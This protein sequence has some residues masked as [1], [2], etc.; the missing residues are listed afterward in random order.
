MLKSMWLLLD[1]LVRGHLVPLDQT[2][3]RDPAQDRHA[4]QRGDAPQEGAPAPETDRNQAQDRDQAGQDHQGLQDR[5]LGVE[6]GIPGAEGHTP[7]G[8]EEVEHG[9]PVPGGLQEEQQGRQDQEVTPGP[10]G[11]RDGPGRDLNAP[12]AEVHSDGGETR[13]NQDPH[14][15][16]IEGGPER[17][18]EHVEGHLL[19]EERVPDAERRR[20]QGL[21]DQLPSVCP[22]PAG[23][24]GQ[25][26][27]HGEGQ[28][29]EVWLQDL[30]TWQSGGVL[31]RHEGLARGEPP[32]KGHVAVQ[33]QEERGARDHP[34]EDLRP[35]H[36]DEDRRELHLAEPQP[37]G[38][39]AQDLADRAHKD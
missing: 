18:L 36:G 39:E 33:D 34:E 31:R 23:E 32:G 20:I 30:W 19:V 6:V 3:V 10:S 5:Q 25:R 14:Q 8:E 16:A 37:V 12:G 11:D 26:H 28:T 13:D 4:H 38:V 9:Q 27:A 15:P 24:E 2:R 21:Q 22:Q 17:E 35:E 1:D 7:L 29:A